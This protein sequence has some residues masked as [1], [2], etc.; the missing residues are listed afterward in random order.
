MAT[1]L[2]RRSVA[3]VTLVGV[4]TYL[5]IVE[6]GIS[7][8]RVHHGVSV[9]G[10]SVGGLSEVEARARLRERALEL[11]AAPVMLTGHGLD[12]PM[13]PAWVSWQARPA[14]T[15][16]RAM[17]V[18]R[19]GAPLGALWDRLRAWFV[20][21]EVKW[22]AK[23]SAQEMK[24]LVGEIHRE[25]RGLGVRVDRFELRRMLRAALTTWP[26]RPVEIP[27]KDA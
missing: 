9:D 18:G 17:R 2:P 3:L 5:V 11:Q 23:P 20:G 26:R 10:V 19:E 4:L 13:W 25:G 15:V 6:L 1:A 14:R 24:G 27:L 8:G 12:R 22:A 16:A 7:A 21:V